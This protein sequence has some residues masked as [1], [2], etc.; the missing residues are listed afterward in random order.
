MARKAFKMQ[1]H[2]G[3]EQEY[4]RRHREIWPELQDLLQRSGISNYS[5]FL[6]HETRTLFG[7]MD[8]ADEHTSEQL[9]N[10]PVMKR[11]WTYMKDIMATNADH[12]PVSVPLEE[13]FHMD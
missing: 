4:E 10:H 11:W 2:E 5:I 3:F 1:L 7:V 6:D 9:P 8:V 12:S 13:V